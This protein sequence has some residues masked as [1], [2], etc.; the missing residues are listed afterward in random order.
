MKYKK[1]IFICNNQ[2]TSGDRKSC[3]ET[4]GLELVKAFKKLISDAGISV[5]VRAQKAGCLDVCD[6][7]PVMVIYPE[8]VFY[9]NVGLSDVD[10]IFHEHVL[11]DRPVERLKLSF[12]KK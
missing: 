10:E 12:D 1:H 6:L 4:H 2:R 3:G 9:G 8:G 5:D 11:N 7:G